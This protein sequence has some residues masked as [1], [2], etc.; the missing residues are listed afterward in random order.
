MKTRLC[1]LLL[2]LTLP[3][4]GEEV[5]VDKAKQAA[6]TFLVHHGS[7]NLKGVSI[8][9]LQLLP[10]VI[11]HPFDRSGKKGAED[12]NPLLYI[13]SI[14]QDDGFIIVSA[15]DHARAI[16]GYSLGGASNPSNLPINYQKWIEG[17]KN[18]IRYIR[19]NP[20]DASPAIMEE[21]QDL[22]KGEYGT[23]KKS[24]S[25]IEPLLTTQWNQSPF[26][27]DLCP[28]DTYAGERTVTG[29]VA[30]A[31]AQIMKF[32]DY[33]ATGSGYYSYA[34]DTYG[35]LSAS[36]G[37]TTY[38]WASMPDVVNSTNQAVATLMYH[39][40]VSVEM[41]YGVPS[42]G[43]SGA[44]VISDRSPV[45]HCVEY[46][47]KNY[48]KYSENMQGVI[49]DYY[50]TASWTALLKT[51]LDAGRPIE[52]AGFGS[53]GGHAFVCDGYN[54]S[55]YFHFNWGWGGA[56]DG[57]FS[58]DALD[59]AGT[60][61][62]GGS[63]GFNSGHQALIGISPPS[64]VTEYDLRLYGE[65][66]ISE[67]PLFYGDP[68]Q[69]DCDLAN[70]ATQNFTG[71]ISAAIFD[72]ESNFIEFVEI[73]E[74]ITMEAG[75][76][77]SV[78]FEN[79]GT[80]T[81]VPGDYYCLFFYR[82][83]GEN[84]E[85]FADG[86]YSN[87]LAVEVYYPNDIELYSAFVIDGGTTLTQGAAM[88]VTTEVANT[89]TGLFSGDLAIDLYDLE[90]EFIETVATLT[91]QSLETGYYYERT[92]NS[93]AITAEP[94]TYLMALTHRATGGEWW[95][96]GSSYAANPMHVIVKAAALTADVYEENDTEENAHLLSAIF[97]NNTSMV[98]TTGS[99]NHLGTDLDYYMMNLDAGFRY[100]IEARAHDSYNSGRVESYTNDV[101]WAWASGDAWSELY[102]DVM[103][104][105]IV[106]DNGGQ[107]VFGVAPYFEGETGTYLLE[108]QLTRTVASSIDPL[109]SDK[110]TI[111]PNPATDILYVESTGVMDMI[112]IYDSRGRK[113][114][115]IHA[116][117]QQIELDV[118]GFEEGIYFLRI[119]QDD[120][121]SIKKFIVQ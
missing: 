64:Q 55:D 100:T 67:D 29:C 43:G 116:G 3:L 60:G 23:S 117:S 103:T 110:L 37:S 97:T 93:S 102:D 68:F 73:L 75:S 54:A 71:D 18:Q 63:G 5:P 24:V 70:F 12:S 6:T 57:Y 120:H 79:E 61:I 91:G 107:L 76:A 58:I 77:Y 8:T 94:G 28:Y 56:Y 84:W 25:A 20:D 83:P 40:G 98:Q 9:N 65:P 118:S 39:C 31:M 59:P 66:I 96:S 33:P 47:L 53:G 2:L 1:F 105:D 82:S 106:L 104:D 85:A 44:Y 38:D 46:A 13:F 111:F 80:L 34:H 50:S 121:V 119:D 89:G 87:Q 17:Y 10:S 78:P 41:S 69:V 90:G 115:S 99:N 26:V 4:L 21:W 22:I 35:S 101:I 16:L 86:S 7:E 42:Q 49:R 88:Q 27:N 48:F 45:E 81:L 92:F 11:P 108:I 52:Y 51:E 114:R 95:L 15:E 112:D 30:T 36:F 113:L 62:G 72:A 19:S 109:L 32:W 14:N 74:N